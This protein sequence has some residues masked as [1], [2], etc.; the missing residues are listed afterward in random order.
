[1]FV[2]FCV[3]FTEYCLCVLLYPFVVWV[4]LSTGDSWMFS[5]NEK[6]WVGVCFATNI[7]SRYRRGGIFYSHFLC[8]PLR[9]TVSRM[10]R[11]I[12][13]YLEFGSEVIKAWG[14]TL[15][16]ARGVSWV[17]RLRPFLLSCL[18]F[19]LLEFDWLVWRSWAACDC[20]ACRWWAFCLR[21]FLSFFHTCSQ[22]WST[23]LGPG[24]SIRNKKSWYQSLP[25]EELPVS[26]GGCCMR[27]SRWSEGM[28]CSV[29]RRSVWMKPCS[30]A[31]Q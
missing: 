3:I 27:S 10:V 20:V 13:L 6:L 22:S 11:V 15:R 31:W 29:S 24:V 5:L 25:C 16:G 18:S 23:L 7:H 9:V 21:C 14:H 30:T 12:S 2:E 8:V 19:H 1:M 26:E 4:K 28:T 17:L